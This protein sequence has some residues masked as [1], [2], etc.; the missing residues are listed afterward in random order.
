MKT[1]NTKYCLSKFKTKQYSLYFTLT[2]I[3]HLNSGTK[4]ERLELNQAL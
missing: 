4:H 3:S 1:I 2:R